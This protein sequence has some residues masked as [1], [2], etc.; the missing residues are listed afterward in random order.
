MFPL[1][2]ENPTELVPYITVAI[3]ALNVIAWIYVEGAGFS[4]P[5]FFNSICKLGLIPAELTGRTDAFRG[6]ELAPGV[7]C[8]FGGHNWFTLLTSMF[9]H[10]GWLHLLGNMWF[11]WVFGNNIED[12]MGHIRFA[13]F[14]LLTGSI[15]G[16]VHI[17]SAPGS[18]VP[19]VGASGAVSGIMGAYLVLYP[20]VR[21]QTLFWIIIFIKII[22]V[23]AWVVLIQWFVIQFLYWLTRSSTE[24]GVAVWAHIGGFIAGLLLIKL[25]EDRRLVRARTGQVEPPH[26]GNDDQEW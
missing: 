26:H 25:F 10:G 4:D 14:Y 9:L 16:L 22:A 20:R 24:G 8:L 11:L 6:V 7:P 17:Y 1:R 23:P 2:D 5:V 13:I 12:S 18:M 19:T 3:I 21:V 15:G